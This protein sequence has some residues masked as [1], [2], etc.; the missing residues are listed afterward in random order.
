MKRA[1]RKI[2]PVLSA[3]KDQ[4]LFLKHNLNA[5]SIASLKSEFAT[6][7]ADVVNHSA[8]LVLYEASTNEDMLFGYH[9]DFNYYLRCMG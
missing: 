3:F 7:E 6:V 4:V 8:D 1:E 2:D 9:S 5:R